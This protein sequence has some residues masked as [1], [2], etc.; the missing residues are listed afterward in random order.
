MNN[1]I[2]LYEA[3]SLKRADGLG[4]GAA[5]YSGA[6]E[7]ARPVLATTLTTVVA[8]LPLCLSGGGSAQRSMSV[9]MTGG[10]V[11]STALTMFVSPVLFAAL[12]RP[13]AHGAR[14]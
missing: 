3:S 14:P 7:R 11:A 9:A 2:L 8:L 6:V 1:A 4:P 13:E 12:G 5:A 10:L